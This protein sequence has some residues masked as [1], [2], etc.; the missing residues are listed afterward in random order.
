MIRYRVAI[1]FTG[2]PD[3]F[4]PSEY[5]A[6]VEIPGGLP[7]SDELER[8]ALEGGLIVEIKERKL[9]VK[10]VKRGQ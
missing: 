10:S 3:G 1:P 9:R 2:C 7:W 8:V 5:P 6:G 4:T